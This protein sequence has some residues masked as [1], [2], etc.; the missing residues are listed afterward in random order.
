MQ[1]LDLATGLLGTIHAKE[2]RQG[3]ALEDADEI[4]AIIAA[5]DWHEEYFFSLDVC[6]STVTIQIW[7]SIANNLKSIIEDRDV[8]CEK[9]QEEMKSTL[10]AEIIQEYLFNPG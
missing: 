3:Y 5:D 10:P 4:Q 2:R 7:M 1:P 8:F 6:L 9:I